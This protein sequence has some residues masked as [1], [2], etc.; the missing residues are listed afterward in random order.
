MRTFI[1]MVLTGV[2]AFAVVTATWGICLV[3]QSSVPLGGPL[4]LR[5]ANPTKGWRLVL[6]RD[7]EAEREL[8]SDVCGIASVPG[9]FVVHSRDGKEFFVSKRGDAQDMTQPPLRGMTA[10]L[11]PDLREPDWLHRRFVVRKYRV[12]FAFEFLIVMG[13]GWLLLVWRN[14]PA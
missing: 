4:E 3:F 7:G 12:L 5:R 2:A 11:H 1:V 6:V 13:I 8:V 9:A 14:S 10:G